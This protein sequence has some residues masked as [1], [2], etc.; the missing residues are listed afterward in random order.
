MHGMQATEVR[1]AL[2]NPEPHLHWV[3]FVAPIAAVVECTGHDVQ[4][5]PVARDSHG[6]KAIE[7][8]LV[9]GSSIECTKA[10][11]FF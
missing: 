6:F 2:K 7:G 3:T 11:E 1:A 10:S 8:A 5:G 4:L 9:C